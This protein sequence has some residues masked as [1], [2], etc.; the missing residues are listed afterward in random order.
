MGTS[1]ITRFAIVLSALSF[2]A[3]AHAQVVATPY[4]YL[5]VLD[6]ASPRFARPYDGAPPTLASGL[7]EFLFRSLTFTP[8]TTGLYTLE[9]I[10]TTSQRGGILP[11]ALVLYQGS[12]DPTQSLVN[13][14]YSITSPGGG[15]LADNL[16]SFDYN[17]SAGS[18]YTLV[19]TTSD[20]WLGGQITNRISGPGGATLQTTVTPEAPGSVLILAGLAAVPLFRWRKC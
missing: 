8:D 17:L 10:N 1:F 15:G 9:T 19:T 20:P 3:L 11:T 12:F 5:S 4:T 2:G 16:V 14:L 7:S 18:S 13:A 6:L